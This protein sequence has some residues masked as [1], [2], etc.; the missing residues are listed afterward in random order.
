MKICP[1]FKILNPPT[2][3][4]VNING[5]IGKKLI[6]KDFNIKISNDGNNSCYLDSL[7]VALFHFRNRAIYNTFFT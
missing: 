2:N 7:L 1:K 5:I 3:R 6:N 4:C